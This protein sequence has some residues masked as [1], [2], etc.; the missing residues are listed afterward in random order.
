MKYLIIILINEAIEMKL[1][2]WLNS[3]NCMSIESNSSSRNKLYTDLFKVMIKQIY[4]LS[5]IQKKE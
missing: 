2:C 1:V 3:Q 4:K 5:Q